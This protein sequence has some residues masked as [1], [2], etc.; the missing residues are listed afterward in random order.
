MSAS[1]PEMPSSPGGRAPTATER[2]ADPVRAPLPHTQHPH[3]LLAS[4]GYA[5]AGL[6]H[7]YLTQ[8]NFRIHLV[9]AILALAA[10]VL[11]GLSWV[12]W[13]VVAVMIVLVLAAEMGN[14]MVEALV[15]LVTEEH[16]PLAEVAK[17]VAAGIVL[18]TAI[19]SL[20][21]GALLF[22]PKLWRLLGW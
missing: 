12:E 1:A 11:F 22:L 20:T 2:P 15:D 5:F 13:A 19:G 10:G 9:I 14:T 21:V 3:P 7:T 6:R 18:L 4:F 8:R 17:D 16:H